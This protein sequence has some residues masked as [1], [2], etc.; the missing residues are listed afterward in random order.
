M[1][2]IAMNNDQHSLTDA[3]YEAIE[4][5]VLETERGRWFLAQ[6][7]K[8]NRNSDTTVLLDAIKKLESAVQPG[9]S[10]SADG[11]VPE[12]VRDDLLEMAEAISRTKREISALQPDAE[13]G[14]GIDAATEELDAI[15][16]ATE[17][18][19]QDILE[20]AE[21]IQEITW[22][23]RELGFEEAYC[24]TIDQLVTGIYTACSF[25]DITGQRTSKVVNV[26]RY[27]ED[28][29][30]AM[31]HILGEDE[32]APPP[33]P[34]IGD[35]RPDA[36]LLNG[37]QLSGA[38]HDQNDID[39]LM[40]SEQDLLQAVVTPASPPPS[41]QTANTVELECD[42]EQSVD[43]ELT[44][45]A[46][47]SEELIVEDETL[48]EQILEEEALLTETPETEFETA[49]EIAPEAEPSAEFQAPVEFEPIAEPEPAV[50]SE[51]VEEI[52][53][54]AEQSPLVQEAAS[55]PVESHPAPKGRVIM[56]R[57]PRAGETPPAEHL[58]VM[59]TVTPPA[60]DPG[61]TARLE[62]L[63]ADDRTA[64]FS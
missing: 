55:A 2:A 18:A 7:A 44:F 56:V 47:I 20:S 17:T 3:D 51:P 16:T 31:R 41:D 14:Q 28:R 60:S 63:S 46:D 9:L 5:A 38:G 32:Q 4:E 29:L 62:E 13:R 23:M 48:A 57:K 37:P 11:P 43:E 64:L 58:N 52:E 21:K 39:L 42:E 10:P 33:A 40:G 50:A 22:T 36:H 15:V 34:S 61:G 35:E 26:L 1:K 24:E 6:F 25:Q 54:V 8:R 45:D 59:E 53:P 27:L 30:A 49:A 19:T 12:Q